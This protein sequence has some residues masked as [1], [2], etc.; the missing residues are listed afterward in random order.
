MHRAGGAANSS[1][2]GGRWKWG[3]SKSGASSQHATGTTGPTGAGGWE[4]HC[5]AGL[6]PATMVSPQAVK[7]LTAQWAAEVSA[8][9][10]KL[11]LPKSNFTSALF[12][13]SSPKQQARRNRLN[14][15][16][17][18]LAC[19]TELSLRDK[20]DNTVNI[21]CVLH[22]VSVTKQGSLAPYQPGEG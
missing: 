6:A 9:L 22:I 20:L 15:E 1:G 17:P 21:V 10:A 7:L 16:A 18:T 12:D 19:T 14:T 13:D 4:G 2:A 5:S 11:T 8:L 3:R